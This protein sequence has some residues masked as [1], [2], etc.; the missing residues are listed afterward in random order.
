MS[1]SEIEFCTDADLGYD[2]ARRRFAADEALTF[3]HSYR[4]THLPLVAPGHPLAIGA[5]AG[6]DYDNGRYASPRYSVVVP[7]AAEALTGSPMFRR[8]DG[9]LRTASFSG[10]IAW[11]ICER[12]AGKLHAS[13]V[14]D[15]AASDTEACAVSLARILPALG[16]LSYRVGGPFIGDRNTGRLY[17]PVY[18][19]T[20]AGRDSFALMQ[21][22]VG[23]RPTRFY[24]V[25]YYHFRDELDRRETADLARLLE[26]WR[27]VQVAECRLST[28]V[29]HA[30]NDNLALSGRP[31]IAVDARSGAMTHP[32]GQFRSAAD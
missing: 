17:F 24:A 11:N 26:H 29:V 9:E 1:D 30:T 10:K 32:A 31:F 27:D 8:I 25:G 4:L 15:L 6:Q 5:A 12:R 13:I 18:P 16:P 28:V 2:A 23:A 19:Q 14:N 3:D 21:E 22:A 7:V 20:V